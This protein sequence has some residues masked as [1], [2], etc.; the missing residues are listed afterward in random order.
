MR[1]LGAVVA[2]LLAGCASSPATVVLEWQGSD[3]GLVMA[4]AAAAEWVDVCGAAIVVGR[5]NGGAP[6]TEIQG[7]VDDRGRIGHTVWDDDGPDFV[8]VSA[9]H[10]R[11][12]VTMTHEL[13]HA[14]GIEH[15]AASGVMTQAQDFSQPA[16]HVTP[17]DCALL[18]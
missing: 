5:G 17:A 15:H 18:P 1:F 9:T 4:Q 6:M 10:G 3:E 16:P 14:L 2:L 7:L 12:Q 8:I 11:R 13:G